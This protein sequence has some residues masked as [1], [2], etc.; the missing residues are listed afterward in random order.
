MAYDDLQSACVALK[1]LL[2][3]AAG[4][5]A[6]RLLYFEALVRCGQDVLPA[7]QT[8]PKRSSAKPFIEVLCKRCGNV[9]LNKEAETRSIAQPNSTSVSAS[10]KNRQFAQDPLYMSSN[11]KADGRAYF[12]SPPSKI[13]VCADRLYHPGE[14][15]TVLIHELQ[16]ALDN[17]VLGMDLSDPQHLA[18]SEVR[19]AKFAEARFLSD[20]LWCFPTRERRS[21]SR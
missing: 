18:C 20:R 10:H 7:K 15:E 12:I 17:E 1:R 11:G 4:P 19:A 2:D 8:N 13:V 16:H 6:S 5:V 3:D 14:M 9:G 21:F